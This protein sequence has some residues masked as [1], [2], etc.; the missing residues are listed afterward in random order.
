MQVAHQ[1]ILHDPEDP[2]RIIL[3]IVSSLITAEGPAGIEQAVGD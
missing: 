1:S 2:S 3:P